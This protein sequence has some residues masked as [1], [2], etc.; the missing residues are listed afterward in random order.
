MLKRLL[1]RNY[2]LI[3]ELDVDFTS[4]LTIITGETGAGKS[5]LIGALSLILGQRADTGV[6]KDKESKCIVEGVFEVEGYGLEPLFAEND[7]DY[8]KQVIFR[9]EIAAN[10]KSRAFVN[11][12]P[13]NLKTLQDL[14]TRLIDIHSQHQSL[15]LGNRQFQLMVLDNYSGNNSFLS[16]FQAKFKAYKILLS[17]LTE[18]EENAYQLRK[19]LDYL[20]FQLAQLTSANLQTG[21]Q[22]KLEHELMLLTHAEDIKSAL[23]SV[24]NLLREE[25]GN[26]LIRV[27][28]S[29][30]MLNRILKFYPEAT[31]YADRL[32]SIYL[33]MSDVAADLSYS[34]EN[35]EVD[36][37]RIVHL[38]ERLDLLYSLQQ[39]HHVSNEGELIQLREDFE[40]KVN[41]VFSNDEALLAL[42]TLAVEKEAEL[43]VL[44]EQ[45]TQNRMAARESIGR[46]VEELLIQLG[47]PNSRFRVEIKTGL[48]LSSN[49][50]DEANFLFTANKNGEP[51]EISKV[52]SGGELSR[53]MLSVKAMISK[54]KALPTI[55]FDEIDSG[56]SGETADK[57]GNILKEI[58]RDM[59]V[60]NIT[61]LP[62]IAAK[63][64]LHYL[65]YKEDSPD[66]TITQL[67]LLSQEERI[68]EVAKMLSG[69][70]ITDAA[71][72]NAVELLK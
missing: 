72:L 63:G 25:D 48:P 56:I 12:T 31:E 32:N 36:P 70:V 21:E 33:E 50:R 59:Q 51:A 42:K 26:A 37:A 68:S 65:V 38:N 55:L 11:D 35:I 20:Q 24:A 53:L 34:S 47:M 67:K 28:E 71:R 30:G 54:S 13:V 19:E 40:Q 39:K 64:D 69:E 58:S 57:M 44:S 23:V 22:E 8:D 15:E 46:K 14:G 2:A 61:H 27:K 60:I 49:G 6:L 7:L 66:E 10:G 9:R 41:G 4:G 52:A 45:L 62:Q 1:I 3:R 29:T 5:I 16:V 17:E 18:A 43:M